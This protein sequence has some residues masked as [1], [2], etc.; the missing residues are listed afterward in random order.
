MTARRVSKW[1]VLAW[2][3]LGW[4]AIACQSLWAH[5]T[6]DS[7]V[8]LDFQRD[9][10]HA[11][12]QMPLPDLLVAQ[13]SLVQMPK[14]AG[15]ELNDTRLNDYMSTHMRVEGA[16][17]HRWETRVMD[18]KLVPPATEEHPTLVEVQIEFNPLGK[19][20]EQ[21]IL[22]ADVVTHEVRNHSILVLLRSDWAAGLAVQAPQLLGS[23][24]HERTQLQVSRQ[25]AAPLA[26]WWSLV[27]M[28]AEHIA[29]GADHLLFVALILLASCMVP[30]QGQWVGTKPTGHALRSALGLVT[31]FTLGHSITLALASLGTVSVP[32][33]WIESMV[34]VSI[35]FSAV[36]VVRPLLTAQEL[37]MAAGF[38]LIHGLAFAQALE[39]LHLET[40]HRVAAL[41]GFNLGI[42]L[43]QI[44]GAAVLLPVW[45][46]V[47]RLPAHYRIRKVVGCLAGLLG[48]L[49][50]LER[51]TG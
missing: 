16:E 9:R 31:A 27:R 32:A 30:H 8:L 13:P 26:A 40:R 22:Q 44:V 42:E 34:A 45:L 37:A 36:H 23:L 6:L 17:G 41:L 49:W 51:L 3:L 48:L 47:L 1:R 25:P 20:L 5:P 38:G 24:S 35:V 2:W 14:G 11:S 15:V 21:F 33:R 46:A 28:G 39:V 43:A 50:L 18:W 19:P 10:L 7:R 4:G 12:V 29:A